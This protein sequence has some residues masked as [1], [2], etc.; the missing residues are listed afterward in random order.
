MQHF[1]LSKLPQPLDLESLISSTTRLFTSFPPE[2]LPFRAW[3]KV[4][5]YSVLKTTQNPAVVHKQTFDYGQDMF[6][7]QAAQIQR[8]EAVQ[9]ALRAIQRTAWVYRRPA[10]AVGLAIAVGALA[11]WLG[12][13]GN[14]ASMQRS[15]FAIFEEWTHRAFGHR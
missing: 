9:K 4:S 3:S 5:P 15:L 1:V 13:S 8:T 2:T 10:G 6:N 7:R 11:L 14:G 12:R